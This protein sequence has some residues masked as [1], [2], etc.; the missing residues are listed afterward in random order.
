MKKII[1]IMPLLLPL[2][3][4][5]QWQADMVNSM[6]GNIQ[7]YKVHCDGINYRYDFSG[8]FTGV[9]IVKPEL[10]QTAILIVEEKKVHYTNTDGMMSQ[11][12]D[13]AQAYAGYLQYGTEKIFE[14]QEV[15]GYKCTKKVVYQ[16]EKPLI[17]QWFSEE[18]NFPVKMENH[19]SEGTFMH[20]DNIQ[21]WKPNPSIFKVPEDFIEVDDEMRPV[22]PE[23]E[24]P[25]EWEEVVSSVPADLEIKRGMLLKIPIDETVYHKMEVNNTGDTPCKFIFKIFVDGVE[26]GED[27]QGP[28]EYRTRRLYMEESYK[29]TH[30]WKAGQ[31]IQIYIFEG[32]GLLKIYKE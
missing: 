12:N 8:D 26:S 20:L 2:F 27:V 17:S 3:T 16:G 4:L 11:M 10:N 5:G 1:L 28:E 32:T 9:V 22:I 23:P 24:P 14:N 15:N 18:L 13:P 21:Y 7:E 25:T 31:E 30:N 19:Y 29:L 6:Q